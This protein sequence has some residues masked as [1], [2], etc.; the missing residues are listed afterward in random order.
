MSEYGEYAFELR[1]YIAEL[2]TMSKALFEL[3]DDWSAE[4]VLSVMRQLSRQSA[5]KW[6]ITLKQSEKLREIKS[7]YGNLLFDFAKRRDLIARRKV[8]KEKLE[9]LLEAA[10]KNNDE[11]LKDFINS[12][13]LQ[14]TRQ[15]PLS[16]K[17]KET[18]QR[19]FHKYR[20]ASYSYNCRN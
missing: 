14:I 1:D 9:K 5:E 6:F 7:K 13:N 8:F 16:P 17:Q 20:I 4:F 10:E 15:K 3:G 11:W 19:S 12:I 18:L 2:N